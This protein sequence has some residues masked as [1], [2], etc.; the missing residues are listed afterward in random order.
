[1]PSAHASLDRFA[2]TINL[3]P[4]GQTPETILSSWLN[5]P[6]QAVGSS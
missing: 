3:L 1:L 6:N 2:V 4:E 5:N